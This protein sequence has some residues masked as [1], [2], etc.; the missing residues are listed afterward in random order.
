MG[1]TG[2]PVSLGG[3]E[4]IQRLFELKA[5]SVFEHNNILARLTPKVA[6]IVKDILNGVFLRGRVLKL[7]NGLHI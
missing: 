4:E 3:I 5:P 1:Y 6:I 7:D 2:G